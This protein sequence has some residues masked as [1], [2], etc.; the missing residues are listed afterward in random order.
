MYKYSTVTVVTDNGPYI[1]KLILEAPEEVKSD[2]ISKDT[3]S[4]YVER[5]NRETGEIAMGSK[6]WMDPRIYP[7]K[8]YREVTDAY[9]CDA[10]G[11]PVDVSKTI[12]IEMPYGPL[13]PL[14][15]ALASFGRA[16]EFV[17]SDYRV[18]Q[19]KEIPGE[20]PISGLVFDIFIKD[21]CEQ[22]EGWNNAKS[23]TGPIQLGY[24]FFTPDF[25]ELRK[26]AKGVGFLFAPPKKEIPDKVPLVIW[27]HGAG[28]GGS[29][30]TLAY[31]G[32]K[33]VNLSSKDIQDKLGG[34]AWVLVPQCPTIWMDD[35][36][37]SY[38][39]NGKSMYTE[40]LMA[41]IEEFVELHK[42]QIDTDRIL[43]GGCSNGGFM[44]MRMIIDYPDYFAAAYPVCEA[45]FD[46]VI[47]DE[48][49]ERIKDI[50][51]WF[52]HA[53][54]DPVV[55]P[56]VTVL[57]TYKRLKEAGAKNVFASY[58][59]KIVDQSGLFK[60]KHGRPHEYMGHFSWIHTYNDFCTQDLDGTRVMI[61]GVPVTL[62][63]WLGMQSK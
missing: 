34:A 6:T 58:F 36:T 27:L 50:P 18:T 21:I 52:T 47:T 33:V 14:G 29:D 15:Y 56:E 37:G 60:D 17:K 2:T 43:I 62:W 16:T 45:L 7:S 32:N 44:T 35:G 28:E 48:E 8:G 41:C 19:V 11:N 20:P 24:G 53:A 63:K 57:P 3:F 26:P 23:T 9:P 12:A 55:R 31:T 46:D 22:L 25:E 39:T 40:A 61:D 13:Y 10:K 49:I 59:D 51:I 42:D 1:T 54:N 30:P 38:T 4:V 5:K